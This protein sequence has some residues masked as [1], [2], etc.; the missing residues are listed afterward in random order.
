VILLPWRGDREQWLGHM[1]RLIAKFPEI[2]PSHVIEFECGDGNEYASKIDSLWNRGPDYLI[3]VEHDI[4]PTEDQWKRLLDSPHPITV[5]PY[6]FNKDMPAHWTSGLSVASYA[7]QLSPNEE[8][9]DGSGIGL[10]K[11]TAAAMAAIDLDGP[12]GSEKGGVGPMPNTIK[13]AERHW[14]NLDGHISLAA[15]HVGV[16]FHVLWPV[17]THKSHPVPERI[18]GVTPDLVGIVPPHWHAQEV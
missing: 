16:R 8:K 14:G 5:F 11:F 4:W 13:F 9:A 18:L 2:Q 12:L 3:I 15:Q 7:G 10:V 17:V 1:R 6:T